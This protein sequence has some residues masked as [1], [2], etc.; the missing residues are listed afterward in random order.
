MLPKWSTMRTAARTYNGLWHAPMELTV[1]FLFSLQLCIHLYL[2]ASL[3]GLGGAL[4]ACVYTHNFYHRPGWSI[5][6]W[7]AINI[8]VALQ[9]FSHLLQGQLVTIWCDSRESLAFLQVGRGQDPILHAV[10]RN[11]LLWLSSIDCN[12]EF[13]HF[14]GS[15]N[16][17][18]DLLSRWSSSRR[19]L[20]TLFSLLKQVTVWYTVPTDS[21]EYTI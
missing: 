16:Q 14:L 18:A 19:P 9:V 17:V 10:A 12:V 1:L 15:L 7:E 13:R 11:I 8:F 3:H 21:L 6:S 4:G 20:A 5:M 2:D